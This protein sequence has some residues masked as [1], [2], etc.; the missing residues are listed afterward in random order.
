[1][2]KL[3]RLSTKE[4]NLVFVPSPVSSEEISKRVKDYDVLTPKQF[5]T[6]YKD[7]LFKPIDFT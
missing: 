5:G 3:K 2:A 1:L 6:K 7:L 4:D